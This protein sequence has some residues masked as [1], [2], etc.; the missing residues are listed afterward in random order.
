VV[1]PRALGIRRLVD[2]GELFGGERQIRGGGGSSW[3]RRCASC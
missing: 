3:E 2:A 1:D